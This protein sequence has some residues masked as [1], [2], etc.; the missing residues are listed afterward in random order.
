MLFMIDLM[1]AIDAVGFNDHAVGIQGTD[2]AT[3]GVI[4]ADNGTIPADSGE[5]A[6]LWVFLDLIKVLRVLIRALML[7]FFF[8]DATFGTVGADNDAVN[9]CAD[10]DAVGG[11]GVD[12][13]GFDVDN[14]HNNDDIK[15]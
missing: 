3:V 10:G 8:E 15:C 9:V 11:D 2:D 12:D 5:N 14:A 6:G 1:A 7:F 13:G 4:G